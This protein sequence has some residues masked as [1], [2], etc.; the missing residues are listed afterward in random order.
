M[1]L[2]KKKHIAAEQRL[3]TS[4]LEGRDYPGKDEDLRLVKRKERE[5]GRDGVRRVL[6][7]DRGGGA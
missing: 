3:R 1:R 6:Q 2:E 7:G 4:I 5:R